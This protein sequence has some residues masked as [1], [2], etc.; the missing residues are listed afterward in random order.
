M[1]YDVV[2]DAA[3]LTINN[4]IHFRLPPYGDVIGIVPDGFIQAC[5]IR[6]TGDAFVVERHCGRLILL[7]TD[8]ARLADA[9]TL[10]A[11]AA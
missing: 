11:S 2:G 9:S 5:D 8:N 4:D 7:P 3:V 10:R 6:E 1:P